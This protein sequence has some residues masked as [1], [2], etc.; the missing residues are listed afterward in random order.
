[1]GRN[2][3]HD[4]GHKLQAPLANWLVFD[5][6][7]QNGYIFATI[8]HLNA[9]RLDPKLELENEHVTLEECNAL[10]GEINMN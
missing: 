2:N 5:I 1:M 7:K 10:F 8:W 9:T 3:Q 6:K 4:K